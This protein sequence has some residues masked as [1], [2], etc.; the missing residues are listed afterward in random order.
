MSAPKKI[1]VKSILAQKR[2]SQ[3]ITVLT[4]YD[5]PFASLFDRAGVDIILIGDSLANVVLGLDSTREVGMAEMIHHAKAARRGVQRALLVGDMPYLSYRNPKEAVK[6]AKRFIKEAGCEAVKLEWFDQ[7]PAVVEAIVKNG[8]PV[9]GHVGLTPQTVKNKKGMKVQGATAESAK[10]IIAAAKAFEKKG[11]FSVVLECIP[12]KIAGII[13]AGLKIPTIGIGA[14]ADCD[15]Q[16]LVAHDLLGLFDRFRPRFVK[17][18]ANLSAAI[19]RAAMHYRDEVLSGKFPAKKHSF[20]MKAQEWEK[21][22][23][24]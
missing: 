17:T 3:K 11:C 8:I 14:G 19:L 24:L 21:I 2:R 9:M 22:S 12:D 1:T 7:C 16:V 13:T 6:N 18:Y 20:G 5:Y 15:G 23:E 10:E 4:A